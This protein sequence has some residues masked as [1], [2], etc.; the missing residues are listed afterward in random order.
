MFFIYIL[1]KRRVLYH[2][3]LYFLTF[4][5]SR[6]IAAFCAF[7]ASWFKLSDF[8]RSFVNSPYIESLFWY[9]SMSLFKLSIIC[10]C[11]LMQLSLFIISDACSSAFCPLLHDCVHLLSANNANNTISISFICFLINFIIYKNL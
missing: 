7:C 1:N 2:C 6:L 4:L 3:Y 5:A 10:A 9:S 11:L 8:C